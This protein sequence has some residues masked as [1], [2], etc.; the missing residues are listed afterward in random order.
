MLETA[1]L[2]I[3]SPFILIASIVSLFIIFA[4]IYSIV[5]IPVGIIKEIRKDEKSCQ[6]QVD[7]R[8]TQK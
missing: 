6:K 3:L 7:Q 2:I 8:N 4:I 1:I 5:M